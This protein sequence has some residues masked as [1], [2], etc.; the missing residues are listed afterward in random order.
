MKAKQIIKELELIKTTFMGYECNKYNT[1]EIRSKIQLMA[2]HNEISPI[3]YKQAL[4]I[5]FN[6]MWDGEK[7]QEYEVL[8]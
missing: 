2:E 5:T 3:E 4:D 1:Q 6:V 8:N 7:A